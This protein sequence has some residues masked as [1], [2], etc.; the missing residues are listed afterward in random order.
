MSM[1]ALWGVYL[2]GSVLVLFCSSESSLYNM[3]VQPS[4]TIGP[5]IWALNLI[6]AQIIKILI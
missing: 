6:K 3:G 1:H 4:L 5:I 2:V